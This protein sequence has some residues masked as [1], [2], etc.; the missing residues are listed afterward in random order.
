M[1]KKHD[2][3]TRQLSTSASSSLEEGGGVMDSEGTIE[4]IPASPSES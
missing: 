1:Y 2:S 4:K 3:F